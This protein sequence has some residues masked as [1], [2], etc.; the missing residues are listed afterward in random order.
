MVIPDLPLES[1]L[2]IV[3]AAILIGMSRTAVSGFG[4]LAIPILAAIFG[5]KESTGIILPMLLTADI[6][7][8]IH[9]RRKADKETFLYLMPWALFGIGAGVIVGG[10]INDRQF[11]IIVGSIILVCVFL[12]LFFDIKGKKVHIPKNIALYGVIGTTVG[13]SSM[14]G[15]SAGPI[16]WIYLLARSLDKTA[17][18]GTS[19]LFFFILNL[20][21]LPLQIFVWDN[22]GIETITQALIV[23]PVVIGSAFAGTHII[24]VINEK[25]FKYIV[26]G[27]T[28]AAA[29]RLLF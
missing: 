18:L 16:L 8:I 19:A 28:A 13:F 20:T 1:W 14:I 7:A 25:V 9:F 22:L 29:L 5:G 24:K 3:L 15:N 10:N 21:K 6:Y 26:I 23:A 2:W 11:S 27:M 12:I 17:F 4:I